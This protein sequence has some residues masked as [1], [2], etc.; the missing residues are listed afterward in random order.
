MPLRITDT[1]LSTRAANPGYILDRLNGPSED[2]EAFAEGVVHWCGITGVDPI[3]AL[4]QW[5]L[6]SGNAEAIRWTR[7]HNPTGIGIVSNSTTQPFAIPDAASAARLHV[8][9][10]YSLVKRGKHPQIALWPEADQWFATVWLPKVQSSA[11]PNVRT[12]V[13]LGLRYSENGDSR[14]TWSWEDGKVAQDTYGKKLVSRA[15]QFYP[16]APDQ[17][18]PP[19]T[20]PSTP[21]EPIPGEGDPVVTYNYDNGVKP[22]DTVLWA[23][24]EGKKYAG[25]ID[26]DDHWVGIVFI[27]SAYGWLESTSDW[28]EGG[29]ALTDAMVGNLLDGKALNGEMREYNNPYGNRYCYAS[30]PVVNPIEDAAKFLELFGPSKEVINA[31]GSAIERTCDQQG[32]GAVTSEEHDSRV[33]R[34]AWLANNYGK[35]LKKTTGKDQFTCDTFP[36]IPSQNNRSFLA[37]HGE[38]N[39]GKRETCPDPQVR[40][41]L[42]RIIADVRTILAGWQKGTATIPP[43]VPPD[44]MPTY[45]PVKPIDALQAYKDKDAAPSFVD[46]GS[47][48]FIFVNDRVKATKATP[49]YQ[50]ANVSGEKI[51]PDIEKGLEFGVLWMFWD[52][53]GTP[54]YIT[55]YWTRVLVADTQR[56]ADAA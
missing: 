38:A 55:P 19:V 50:S 56:I 1:I 23:V 51:G 22:Q 6:E 10:L 41:T 12:V 31:H 54:W 36:L 33:R 47:D 49:R 25:W 3:V 21:E 24:S 39:A 20:P 42:N 30:G 15:K 48:T 29:N 17:N 9:C 45:S 28:F 27:H 43:Q 5:L 2:D 35:Y 4:A 7:D 11:M 52:D 32:R 13:D 37:Y 16:E 46:V 14:A 53:K 26:P 40:A 34:I 18:N 44:A 8:Q